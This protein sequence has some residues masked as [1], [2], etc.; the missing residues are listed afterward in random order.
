VA[1]P[2][3]CC[4]IQNSLNVPEQ[5]DFSV[6]IYSSDCQRI[7]HHEFRTTIVTYRNMGITIV[8]ADNCAGKKSSEL[9]KAVLIGPV[10]LLLFG[11]S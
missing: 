6:P 10:V 2:H 7:L 3:A 9:L 1:R 8:H 11:S 4:K 5:H